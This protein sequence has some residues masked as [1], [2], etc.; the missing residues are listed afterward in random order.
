MDLL[1]FLLVYETEEIVWRNKSR[2]Q[3]TFIEV[4]VPKRLK[5]F[6]K[7]KRREVHFGNTETR[8]PSTLLQTS[9]FKKDLPRILVKFLDIFYIS[10]LDYWE[11]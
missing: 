6:S 5:K 9:S 7:N 2:K 4:D 10:H 1:I 11:L 8:K 3:N